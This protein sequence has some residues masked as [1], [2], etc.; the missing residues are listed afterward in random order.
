MRFK[1]T[2][3]NASDNPH[4]PESSAG[5]PA[6]AVPADESYDSDTHRRAIR[7]RGAEPCV[8]ARKNRLDPVAYDRYPNRE[9]RVVELY[10]GW[11]KQY[12]RIATRYEK[13]AQNYLRFVRVALIA[14]MLT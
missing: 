5:V 14:L 10:L 11:I 2:G 12:H 6:G 3:A 9:R 13:K 1:L 7:G 8:P 4:L